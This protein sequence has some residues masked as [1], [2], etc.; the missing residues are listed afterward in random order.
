MFNLLQRAL[1]RPGRFDNHIF[2]GKPDRLE[3]KELLDYYCRRANV[4]RD[5]NSDKYSKLTVGFSSAGI[6]NLVNLAAL[7]AAGVGKMIVD[8][9]DFNHAFDRLKMGPEKVNQIEEES[10]NWKTAIHEAG[11]ALA[12]HYTKNS[13]DLNKVTIKARGSSLG[14]VISFFCLFFRKLID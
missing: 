4:D 10:V 5:L 12:L 13:M 11:H 9:H 8:E 6:N 1:L 3:R 14:H 2:V 7:H